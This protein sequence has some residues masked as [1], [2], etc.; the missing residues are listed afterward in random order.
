[1]LDINEIFVGN[2]AS[3]KNSTAAMLPSQFHVQNEAEGAG[4]GLQELSV[5]SRGMGNEKRLDGTPLS[6]DGTYNEDVL[7]RFCRL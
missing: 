3:S 5:D 2:E 1:M 7:F 6:Q 4:L